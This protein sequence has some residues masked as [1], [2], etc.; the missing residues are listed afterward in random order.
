MRTVDAVVIGAGHNGLVAANLLVDAGWDVLVLEATDAA[1]GSVR[2]EELTAP[3]FRHDTCSAF[4]PLGMA[5]PVLRELDLE[6]H[7]LVWRHAPAVLAHV[8]P[9]DRCALLSRDPAETAES[10]AAFDAHDGQAWLGE[11]GRWR[12]VGAPLLEAMLRPFPPMRAGVRLL[13]AL[14][15]AEALRFSRMAVQPVDDFGRE[16]FRGAGGQLLLAGNAL[17][18]DLGTGQAG[19]AIFGWLL[20][21]LGQ[22]VGFPVPA[23]GGGQLVEALLRRLESRGG[24]VE[25]G[26]AVTRILHARATAVGVQD[27]HGERVRARRAVLADVSAPTLYADLVGLS[28]LPAAMATDVR[29][30]QWDHAT[31]KID[32]ALSGPIPWTAP[33]ARRAGTI[34]LGADMAGLAEYST[35]LARDRLPGHP[36]ILL[37]QMTTSDPSRSPAG[38]ESVWAYT[39][40]PQ[41]M[42]RD[43]GRMREQAERMEGVIE[44]RAPGFRA[45]VVARH[46]QLP[47]DLQRHNP[48]LFG[49]AV[50]GGTAALHQQ[51][52]FRPV[53]GLARADTPIDRLY[54]ASSSA[55]P[56]GGVH[57]APGANAARAALA[58]NGAAGPAYATV[59]GALHRRLYG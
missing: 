1:G 21:M 18:T 12:R 29:R 34:H 56:G 31:I 57:G 49:G 24:T 35:D 19:S 25:Y 27:V 3:G 7:G 6:S 46:V 16:R 20:A 13:R 58:R 11:V 32:W 33:D 54:L 44:R 17:H 37:G 8:L 53:P 5:S 38:T 14:G 9:D 26:R 4:Y 52:F 40:V 23:G 50:N 51:L 45:S 30:F 55:H 59:I 10:L 28:G 15:A 42:A 48:S 22:S 41:R 2:T 43:T 39:H 47:G 36:F